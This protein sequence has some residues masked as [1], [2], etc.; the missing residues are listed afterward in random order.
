MLPSQLPGLFNAGFATSALRGASS[1]PGSRVAGAVRLVYKAPMFH[2]RAFSSAAVVAAEV[3]P[4]VTSATAQRAV[5]FWLAGGAAWVFSMVVLGGVTRL[6][7]SGLSMTEWKF[8]GEKT[9]RTDA[10]WAGEF[11]KY[12]SSPEFK[13]VNSRMD[14]EEFKFIFWME[15]AH[16]MWGRYL[17]VFFAVPLA[18][19]AAKGYL[20]APL[21]RRLGLLFLA[22][23][24]QGFVGWWMVKSGLEAPPKEHDVPRVSPYRLATHLTTAFAIYTALLWTTLDVWRPT[25]LLAGLE[26]A[27]RA[28]GK[29]A[30]GRAHMLAALVGITAISGAFVAGM[31]AGHA[32]NTFPLMAGR[33]IP[34][35]YWGNFE[36]AWRN[37]F[38]N[39]AAVQFH[40]RVLAVS[41]LTAI[42]AY[43]LA[44]QKL[45]LPPAARLATHA[46]LAMACTQVTLG[47]A[48]LLTYVPVSLGSAHQAGAL[49]LFSIVI[50]LM[51]S[52]RR[53]RQAAAVAAA[54]Q[55]AGAAAMGGGVRS[56]AAAGAGG[57][58]FAASGAL[59]APAA[60]VWKA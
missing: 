52:L 12:K 58:G 40:H 33:V 47:I 4:L 19:F 21:L 15:Y 7:R 14:L 18:A 44:A 10:D 30:R 6:T 34:E 53:P 37:A 41:T 55:R 5:G 35:E 49:T 59:R 42:S 29:V 51:H 9:P 8:T 43:W 22:G 13:K 57:V 31:D 54:A 26:D 16:R 27:A 50:A 45:P 24:S 23:A 36:P 3:H 1:Q 2:R 11:A 25:P 46:L 20:R 56:G 48:T 60:A 28:A 38:E 39:T 17:G 32:Y